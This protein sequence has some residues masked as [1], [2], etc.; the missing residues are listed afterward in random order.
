[1]FSKLPNDGNAISAAS[2]RFVGQYSALGSCSI[3]SSETL[4]VRW[5]DR[6]N[7]DTIRFKLDLPSWFAS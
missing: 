1:M 7:I 3:R 5:I 2:H 6:V 4:V